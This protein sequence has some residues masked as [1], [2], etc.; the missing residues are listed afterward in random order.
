MAIAGGE[1]HSH[2]QR[3]PRVPW[4]RGPLEDAQMRWLVNVFKALVL[5]LVLLAG[6]ALLLPEHRTVERSREIAAPAARIWPL[7][8]APRQW[9]GWSPWLA[10]DPAMQLA[11]AGAESGAGAE[12]S[13]RSASQGRG[14]MRFDRTEPPTRLSYTLVFDDMGSTTTGEFVLEP[15]DGGVGGGKAGRT[16]VTWR[17]EADFGRN[18]PMRWFGLLLDRTVGADFDAGLARL[19]ARVTGS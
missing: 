1:P 18:L 6:A 10:K 14:H 8:V 17:L 12:W 19:D 15:I 2:A 5:L 4:F 3:Y 7:L 11:Y 16:R 13:W 9:A